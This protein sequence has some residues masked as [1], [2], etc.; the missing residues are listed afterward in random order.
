MNRQR[1][2]VRLPRLHIDTRHVQCHW[3]GTSIALCGQNQRA[4]RDLKQNVV[5]VAQLGQELAVN[6]YRPA[7]CPSD[8]TSQPVNVEPRHTSRRGWCRRPNASAASALRGQLP[9]TRSANSGETYQ[10]RS[11]TDSARMNRP[12]VRP[13]SSGGRNTH[14]YLLFLIPEY[15]GF[16]G[17][18]YHFSQT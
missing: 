14:L 6:E 3:S 5:R 9:R 8:K 11:Q 17:R 16:E 4:L 13:F 1:H 15:P 12:A 2:V 10:G 7:N 18:V